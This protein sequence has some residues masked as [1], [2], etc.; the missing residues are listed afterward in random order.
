MTAILKMFSLHSV[1]KHES[2]YGPACMVSGADTQ[3]GKKKFYNSRKLYLAVTIDAANAIKQCNVGIK[4]ATITP[5]EKRLEG[6]DLY[7]PC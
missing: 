3:K 5:D 4:C 1:M 6:K 7:D 2:G